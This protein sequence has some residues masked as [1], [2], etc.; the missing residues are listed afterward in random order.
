MPFFSIIHVYAVQLL[1][2]YYQTQRPAD[3]RCEI[4]CQRFVRKNFVYFLTRLYCR[5][6]AD[7]LQQ[8]NY[9][10]N[11]QPNVTVGF[12]YTTCLFLYIFCFFHQK[13]IFFLTVKESL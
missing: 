10:R 3:C 8:K 9:P 4:P 2:R 11:K 1:C 12:F 13:D 5:N 6:I 7:D